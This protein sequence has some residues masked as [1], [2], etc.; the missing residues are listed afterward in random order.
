MISC[1]FPDVGFCLPLAHVQAGRSGG[2]HAPG[3]PEIRRG[4]P[5]ACQ[6]EA[7]TTTAPETTSTTAALMLAGARLSQLF[8]KR[9]L[10]SMFHAA[11]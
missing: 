6:A 5:H 2:S 9:W 1:R 3:R 10:M 8:V 4:D 7:A 11:S